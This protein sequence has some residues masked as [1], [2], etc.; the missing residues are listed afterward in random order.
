MQ[1]PPKGPRVESEQTPPRSLSPAPGE[2]QLR[3][4]GWRLS[5]PGALVIAVV[6]AVGTRYLPTQTATDTRLEEARAEQRIRDLREAEFR[7]EVRDELRSIR[8]LVDRS[9]D[10][11]RN[12]LVVLEERLKRLERLEK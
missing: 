1:L 7:Q 6:S 12:R 2:L 5:L 9:N 8:E 11:A 4:A 10:E 3:G